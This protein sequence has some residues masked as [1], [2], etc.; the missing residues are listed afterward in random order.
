MSHKGTRQAGKFSAIPRLDGAVSCALPL[1]S[2]DLAP[3]PSELGEGPGGV[4]WN[5]YLNGQPAA[6]RLRLIAGHESIFTPTCGDRPQSDR[7]IFIFSSGFH[8]FSQV[9]MFRSKEAPA[10]IWNRR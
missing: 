9:R 1:T 8:A 6:L 10:Y 7:G 4:F 5:L 3:P 2:F